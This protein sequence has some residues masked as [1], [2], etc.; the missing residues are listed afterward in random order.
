M[1]IKVSFMREDHSAL[2]HGAVE[3]LQKL[4]ECGH[5]ELQKNVDACQQV[6]ALAEQT[7]SHLQKIC[8]ASV[9]R[10][11]ASKVVAQIMLPVGAVMVTEDQPL[12]VQCDWNP[13]WREQ[14][15]EVCGDM[16]AKLR[17]PSFAFVNH[18]GRIFNRATNCPIDADFVSAVT[19]TCTRQLKD[20]ALPILVD[21]S[22]IEMRL[23]R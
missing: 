13:P 12:V 6:I 22:T 20:L 4:H 3:A 21:S 15:D 9:S 2:I 11:N 19:E 16:N 23:Q 5:E 1:F 18:D 14:V 17:N 8:G 7:I 10:I